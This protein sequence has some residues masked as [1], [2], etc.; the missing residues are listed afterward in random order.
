M[1]EWI[2]VVEL[3][4]IPVL[5]SRVIKTQEMDI[6]VFRGSDDQVYAIRDACPHKNGPLS[7]GIMH[8]TSVTCPLHNWK[9]DLNSGEALGPDEGCANVF[10]ARVED[11]QV[12]LQLK[13]A[14][15]VV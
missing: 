1:S 15:A 3:T 2:E 4:Q 6:A 14:E 13:P 7:Q 10:P 12:Y 9:I 5:G 8:G 11:G